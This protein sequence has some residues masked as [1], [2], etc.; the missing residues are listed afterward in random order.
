MHIEQ[1]S[2]KVMRQYRRDEIAITKA[3]Y[4]VPATL[5]EQ[6]ELSVELRTEDDPVSL[7]LTIEG[8]K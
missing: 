3:Y 8:M 7:E 2:S 1:W 4:F 5:S 6:M